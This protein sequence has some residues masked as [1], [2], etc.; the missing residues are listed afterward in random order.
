MTG[1][2]TRGRTPVRRAKHLCQVRLLEEDRYDLIE[3]K[4]SLERAV[5]E[6]LARAEVPAIFVWSETCRISGRRRNDTQYRK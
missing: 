6:S 4:V 1:E 3:Q 5:E 2:R